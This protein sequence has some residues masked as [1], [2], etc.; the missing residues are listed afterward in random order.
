MTH[1]PLIPLD[2]QWQRVLAASQL[3]AGEMF[4]FGLAVQIAWIEGWTQP[5]IVA[6]EA[7]SA[8]L[9]RLTRRDRLMRRGVPEHLAGKGLHLVTGGT[10]RA[11]QPP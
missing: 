7:R 5:V 1:P 8:R 3:W 2:T 6:A 9:A 11:D 10:R 4:V